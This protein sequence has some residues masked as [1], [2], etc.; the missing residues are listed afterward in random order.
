EP[1]TLGLLGLGL[2]GLAFARRKK[3]A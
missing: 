2:L 3:A 1:G